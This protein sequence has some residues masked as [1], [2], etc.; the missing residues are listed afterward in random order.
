LGSHLKLPEQS[1]SRKCL[2]LRLGLTELE[3]VEIGM[4][5]VCAMKTAIVIVC[6]VEIGDRMKTVIRVASPQLVD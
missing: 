4:T 2:T 1:F 5:I 3:S 6:R